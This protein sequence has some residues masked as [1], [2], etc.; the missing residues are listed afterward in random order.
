MGVFIFELNKLHAYNSLLVSSLYDPQ[1]E[2]PFCPP[3]V[4]DSENALKHFFL[5][6]QVLVIS[7]PEG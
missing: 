5:S 2:P 1:V 4:T 3:W 7:L 6:E